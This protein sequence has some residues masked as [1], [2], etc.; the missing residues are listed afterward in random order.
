MIN[1]ICFPI[2]FLPV[3]KKKDSGFAKSQNENYICVW[4]YFIIILFYYLDVLVLL[5]RCIVKFYFNDLN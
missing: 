3:S 4:L 5:A 1:V 2:F